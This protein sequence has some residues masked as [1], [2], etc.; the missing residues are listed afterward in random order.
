M[1]KEAGN[2]KIHRTRILSIYNADY[3]VFIGIMWK[4]LLSSSEKRGALNRDLH[5]DRRSHN[6]QTLSL[7][8]EL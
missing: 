7:I 8:E 6:A 4:D 2:N 5:G 3:S 1:G